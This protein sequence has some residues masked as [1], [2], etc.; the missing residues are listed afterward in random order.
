[1]TTVIP[2]EIGREVSGTERV[3][4]SGQPRQGIVFRGADVFLVPFSLLWCGFA[5]FWEASVLRAPKAPGLFAVWGVPFV[6][7]GIY[8]VAG[9]FFT[10]AEQRKRTF[11]A[12]TNERV[13]IVS[14]LFARSVKSLDLRTLADLSLSEGANGQGSISFGGGSNFGSMSGGMSSWPGSQANVGPRFDLIPNA[15]AVY[16]I[17]RNAQRPSSVR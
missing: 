13:V 8:M 9:R 2:E 17:I 11:Y 12:V 7:A 10:D 14:G 3:L 6:C 15:R 4:W 5:I 1:L 16:D